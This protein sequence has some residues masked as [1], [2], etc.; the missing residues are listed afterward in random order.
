MVENS[1][2]I[3]L[4]PRS[5]SSDKNTPADFST[6][7]ELPDHVERRF[8]RASFSIHD[9]HTSRPLTLD[10]PDGLRQGLNELRNGHTYTTRHS[11]SINDP[12]L[13]SPVSG[14]SRHMVTAPASP[15]PV[16][17][18][19]SISGIVFADPFSPVGCST[20]PEKLNRTGSDRELDRTKIKP[21]RRISAVPK[22]KDHLPPVPVIPAIYRQDSTRLLS[23]IDDGY[24]RVSKQL[25]TP[26]QIATVAGT[27]RDDV[28]VDSPPLQKDS[29]V[30]LSC[31]Q[32][33][34]PDDNINSVSDELVHLPN[35]V[36][37]QDSGPETPPPKYPDENMVPVS[38]LTNMPSVIHPH[39]PVQI[40]RQFSIAAAITAERRYS[41]RP[42][43][44]SPIDRTLRRPSRSRSTVTLDLDS[45]VKNRLHV[46]PAVSSLVCLN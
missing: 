43:V 15:G 14:S 19:V 1:P 24:S 11:W 37:K 12:T 28:R 2:I 21:R 7:D 17:G 18:L 45:E 41:F 30:N 38:A 44:D 10:D 13:L 23:S 16:S 34:S 29:S 33:Y 46:F 31:I 20:D 22:P 39:S 36:N 35:S 8:D 9:E 26:L 27:D 3:D 25:Q 40:P 32:A 5:L 42:E 6:S 4:P